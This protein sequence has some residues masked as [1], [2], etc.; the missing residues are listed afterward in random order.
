MEKYKPLPSP[1]IGG[2][3]ISA[4]PGSAL[5]PPPLIVYVAQVSHSQHR[6]KRKWMILYRFGAGRE[7][8][9]GCMKRAPKSG[10]SDSSS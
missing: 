9:P 7:I 6:M 4:L 10:M 3:D 1:Y 2:A 8:A 5:P